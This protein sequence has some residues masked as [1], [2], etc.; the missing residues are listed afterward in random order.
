MR[1]G[2]LFNGLIVVCLIGLLV[3]LLY[4]IRMY[5]PEAIASG[6]DITC[7][8]WGFNVSILGLIANILIPNKYAKSRHS[9]SKV[10]HAVNFMF[11]VGLI[12]AI[13]PVYNWHSGFIRH[14]HGL[15][16]SI[17]HIH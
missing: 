8:T 10:Y 12:L 9:S 3:S 16:E 7:A 1:L 5:S 4:S 13:A 17:L 11:T 14:G 15:A 2:Y 6:V